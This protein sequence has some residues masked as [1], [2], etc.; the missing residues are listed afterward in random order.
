MGPGKTLGLI[1][2]VDKKNTQKISIP[3]LLIDCVH[4]KFV[5][6]KSAIAHLDEVNK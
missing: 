6:R 1:Q 5:I 4:R 2:S 3:S